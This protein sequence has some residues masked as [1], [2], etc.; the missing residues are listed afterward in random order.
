MCQNGRIIIYFPPFC[1]SGAE[2]LL[3]RRAAVRVRAEP[4]LRLL[5]GEGARPLQR[6][7]DLVLLRA[8]G[9]RPPPGDLM[10]IT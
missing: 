9:P 5:R 2:L 8:Q 10:C 4:E 1:C 6:R 3:V 7:H